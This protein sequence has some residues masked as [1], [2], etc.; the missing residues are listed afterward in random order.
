LELVRGQNIISNEKHRKVRWRGAVTLIAVIALIV[1]IGQTSLGHEILERAGLVRQPTSY[2]SLAFLRPQSLP[3]QLSSKQ[4]TVSVSFVIHNTDSI[5]H[6]YQW[7]VLLVQGQHTRHVG[8]GSVRVAS[9]HGAAITRPARISCT[10]GQVQVVVRLT[11]P[12]EFIDAWTS[13]WSPK[14]VNATSQRH[15]HES[16]HRP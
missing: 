3:E 5:T 13:C 11:R 4:T 15:T 12:A 6:D 2:T 8:A 16:L 9:G 14:E 7:S 1:G 10:G